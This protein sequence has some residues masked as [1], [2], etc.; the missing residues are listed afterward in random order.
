[1]CECFV[2]VVEVSGVYER[3]CRLLTFYAR[4]LL[5]FRLCLRLLWKPT[6]HLHHWQPRRLLPAQTHLSSADKLSDL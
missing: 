1:M 5:T 4:Q 6:L 2:E 3:G